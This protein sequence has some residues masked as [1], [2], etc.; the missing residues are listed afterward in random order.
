MP[1][2][3]AVL[4]LVLFQEAFDVFRE[5]GIVVTRVVGRFAMVA[6]VNGIDRSVQLSGKDSIKG[7]S[8]CIAGSAS[9]G[10]YLLM[11]LLFFFE[12]KRP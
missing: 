9:A 10:A 2:Q 12:P 5:R 6:Q 8:M 3:R 7:I 1:D 11:L 4:D